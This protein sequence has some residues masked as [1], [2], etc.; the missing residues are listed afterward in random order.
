MDWCLILT[1]S[2]FFQLVLACQVRVPYQDLLS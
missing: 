2:K 1:V